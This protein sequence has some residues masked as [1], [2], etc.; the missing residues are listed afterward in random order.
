MKKTK[1]ITFIEWDKLADFTT[2][3]GFFCQKSSMQII[4]MALVT[5]LEVGLIHADWPRST[6]RSLLIK[7]LLFYINA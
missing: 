7:C 2:F 4:P 3:L 6:Y 1:G 5:N